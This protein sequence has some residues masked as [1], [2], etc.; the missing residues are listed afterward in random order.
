LATVPPATPVTILRSG[1]T[2]RR[3]FP[4]PPQFNGP[5]DRTDA[6]AYQRGATGAS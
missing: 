1:W 2:W 4:R 5:P 6:E 3:F